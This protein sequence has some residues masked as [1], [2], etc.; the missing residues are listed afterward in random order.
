VWA[1]TALVVA[2]LLLGVRARPSAGKQRAAGSTVA[3]A[4]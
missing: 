1:G 2:G 3:A 4:R